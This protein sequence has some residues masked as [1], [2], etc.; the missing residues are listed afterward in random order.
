MADLMDAFAALFSGSTGFPK[1]QC[2]RLGFLRNPARGNARAAPAL[3]QP[4]FFKEL[5]ALGFISV[6]AVARHRTERISDAIRRIQRAG[7][8]PKLKPRPG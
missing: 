4:V 5:A 6:A 3:E 8:A 7:L 1:R 2:S